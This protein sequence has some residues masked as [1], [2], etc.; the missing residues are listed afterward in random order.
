[1][2]VRTGTGLFRMDVRRNG[3]RAG[4]PDQQGSNGF[5]KVQGR[6]HIRP[7]AAAEFTAAKFRGGH[8]PGGP[9]SAS[10]LLKAPDAAGCYAGTGGPSE[11]LGHRRLQ[12]GAEGEQ[13]AGA[14]K[15][16]ES[17]GD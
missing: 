4:P 9:G 15:R 12:V 3:G 10:H 2:K 16:S 5:S 11:S 13:G 14:A 8:G 17:D 1:M 6:P 7:E